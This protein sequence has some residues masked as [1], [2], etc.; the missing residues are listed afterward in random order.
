[1]RVY[2]LINFFFI[3]NGSTST[4]GQKRVYICGDHTCA[5]NKEFKDYFGSVYL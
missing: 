2:H 3:I 1:M 5:N 4:G